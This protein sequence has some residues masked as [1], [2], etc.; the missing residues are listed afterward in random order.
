MSSI[1]SRQLRALSQKLDRRHVKSRKA[2]DG[3]EISYVEGWFVI[4]EANAIFGF[5]GWDRETVHFERVFETSTASQSACGYLTRVRIRVKAQEGF[6]TREGTG[7]GSASAKSKA[8]AH[9]WALK[10]SETDA[11]KRA[12]A[13]FGNRFGLALYDKEQ[14]G[15]TPAQEKWNIFGPDGDL[16]VTTHS[17]ESYCSALRQVIEKLSDN[18]LPAWREKNAAGL[19]HLREKQP[20]LRT[21]K[22]THYADIIY[23]LI[24]RRLQKEPEMAVETLEK[25]SEQVNLL[26]PSKIGAAHR[27]DKSVLMIGNERRIRDKAHLKYVATHPCLICGRQPT[28]A[29]HLTFAQKRGLGQK[30]SDEFTVPL[31]ALHHGELHR[32][33]GEK[34]WWGKMGLDPLPT[35]AELWAQSRAGTKRDDALCALSGPNGSGALS[36]L[37]SD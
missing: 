5:T 15:V 11:T 2:S 9:D 31:C 29:H 22:G 20:H 21:K 7:F 19:S 4:A 35:S 27:I 28:H 36:H 37:T 1:Y 6:V 23:Q 17:G 10:A 34:R 33:G 8:E 13:T 12:L 24:V 18:E 26:A 16:I 3:H 32:A 14:A 30:V 25:G